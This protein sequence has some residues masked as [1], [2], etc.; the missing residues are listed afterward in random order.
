MTTDSKYDGKVCTFLLDRGGSGLFA[1][2]SEESEELDVEVCR[3]LDE[4]MFSILCVCFFL[5]LFKS[6]SSS[7]ASKRD[8]VRFHC[9][10][11]LVKEEKM[12]HL[13]KN[14]GLN[15]ITKWMN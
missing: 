5:V 9:S 14:Y 2:E 13:K 3:F 15:L 4:P 1:E 10:S 11:F 6:A 8:G 12:W 7:Q